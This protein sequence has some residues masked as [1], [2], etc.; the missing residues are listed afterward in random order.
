MLE[1]IEL[2]V[3]SSEI[4]MQKKYQ[5]FLFF[6]EL[7]DQCN[8][9]E[10][11]CNNKMS[12]ESEVCITYTLHGFCRDLIISMNPEIHNSKDIKFYLYFT[13]KVESRYTT[14]NTSLKKSSRV[15]ES[16]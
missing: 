13:S 5:C 10:K 4:S 7:F 12:T 1:L 2:C 8:W 6:L 14:S 15:S 16:A 3:S 9:K 11:E